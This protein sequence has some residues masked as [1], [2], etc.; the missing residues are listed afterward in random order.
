M[1]RRTV[2]EEIRRVVA[3]LGGT[4]GTHAV[5]MP[6]PGVHGAAG[7]DVAAR[8][9]RP[10][11]AARAMRPDPPG[12]R[13]VAVAV[14]PSPPRMRRAVHELHAAVRGGTHP[15]GTPRIRGTHGLRSPACRV[16][17]T[18]PGPA[19]AHRAAVC[20]ASGRGTRVTVATARARGEV[21]LPRAANIRR[22]RAVPPA[23]FVTRR[24][25]AAWDAIER[26]RLAAGWRQ[27]LVDH[28]LPAEQLE[29][30]GIY[31]PL[32]L[33]LVDGVLLEGDGRLAVTLARRA[34]S[35]PPGD[36]AIARHVPS[37]RL[38]RSALPHGGASG[39][40]LV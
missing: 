31:G 40:P 38:L 28:R 39:R 36:V 33:G 35:G 11:V 9:L 7:P 24:H 8:A 29:L 27:V 32:P 3:R 23:L 6:V 12:A 26:L 17:A 20:R 30:V 5:D 16:V 21:P 4:P 10:G 14:A 22:P 15:L 2:G 25:R 19:R 18:R 13:A 1:A 34:V 37:G